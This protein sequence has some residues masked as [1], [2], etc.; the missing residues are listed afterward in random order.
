MTIEGP[1]AS[2][3]PTD[4]PLYAAAAQGYKAG[5]VPAH[6]TAIPYYAWANRGPAAMRVWLAKE[7]A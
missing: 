5:H 3:L 6:I 2:T 4:Q 1:G 7:Q